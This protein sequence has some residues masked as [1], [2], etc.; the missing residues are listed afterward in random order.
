MDDGAVTAKAKEVARLHG[1]LQLSTEVEVKDEKVNLDVLLRYGLGCDQEVAAWY[2]EVVQAVQQRPR[3]RGAVGAPLRVWQ[4]PWDP[5]PAAA[6]GVQD[7]EEVRGQAQLLATRLSDSL[8]R[9]HRRRKEEFEQDL[10]NEQNKQARARRAQVDPEVKSRIVLDPFQLLFSIEQLVA[11][12]GHSVDDDG[13]SEPAELVA[14]AE[15]AA[16]GPPAVTYE[17]AL[18]D[19]QDEFEQGYR[20]PN[21]A[22]GFDSVT[23]P[24][25][26]TLVALDSPDYRGNFNQFAEAV[27]RS[28]E[29]LIN[30]KF[31]DGARARVVDCLDELAFRP[32]LRHT[33]QLARGSAVQAPGSAYLQKLEEGLDA[34]A[35]GAELMGALSIK[36]FE[37]DQGFRDVR[38]EDG[39]GFAN[40]KCSDKNQRRINGA[41]DDADASL[42]G[43]KPFDVARRMRG[44]PVLPH[45]ACVPTEWVHPNTVM[46]SSYSLVVSHLVA[47]PVAGDGSPIDTT[48]LSMAWSSKATGQPLAIAAHK[49]PVFENANF[50]PYAYPKV[51]GLGGTPEAHMIDELMAVNT[52]KDLPSE[53]DLSFTVLPYVA[54]QVAAPTTPRV[55]SELLKKGAA[56]AAK[57]KFIQSTNAYEL[58]LPAAKANTFT[59]VVSLKRRANSADKEM[60][61]IF[62]GNAEA[63]GRYSGNFALCGTAGRF[64]TVVQ[65]DLNQYIN[66]QGVATPLLREEYIN[67]RGEKIKVGGVWFWRPRLVLPRPCIMDIVCIVLL[68]AHDRDSTCFTL[69]VSSSCCS[70]AKMKAEYNNDCP[71]TSSVSTKSG[72]FR[73]RRRKCPMTRIISRPL[74]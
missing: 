73:F 27:G 6:Q 39:A 57:P 16:Q 33:A 53:M 20:T 14:A 26:D 60:Q 5:H 48:R 2:A 47:K 43:L 40:V 11:A 59:L 22:A 58:E 62:C 46:D 4:G 63:G 24:A 38:P 18:Q 65:F 10:N 32:S 12:S 13:T 67:D 52:N 21:K 61:P 74:R 45:D 51:R 3:D 30:N 69:S 36:A 23:W 8:K 71:Y 31:V 29:V 72:I 64:S 37:A 55:V 34:F 9:C 66:A 28:A 70:S 1:Q 15:D 42:I 7:I 19:L 56:E 44:T 49:K 50:T 54:F 41:S 68:E 17:Q 25:W 35:A